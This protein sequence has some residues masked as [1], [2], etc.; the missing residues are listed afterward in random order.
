MA[1][2]SESVG[3]VDIIF[4]GGGTAACVAAGRLAKA[5]PDL[6]ILLVEGGRNN[7]NDPTVVN[8][9][10]YLSHLAP[11]STSALFYKAKS[12]EHLG[13]REAIVPMGG[14]LGGGSSINFMMYTRAQ[15]VD[16]DSW[17]TPGWA[18]KDM[19]PL[20][21]KL[22]T[23]HP[24]DAAID[25]SKHGHDGPIHI[26]DGGYR[27]KSEDQF[28]ETVT[29]MGHKEIVDLQDL[30]QCGG[31]SKWHRYI[32]PEGKR[33][34]S[35]HRYVHPLVEN[36]QQSNLYLLVESKVI[37][38]L[39]DESSPPRAIGIEYKPNPGAQP[40]ISLSKPVH[41]TVKANK[42]VVVTA[43]ALGTP[44]I[45]ERSG[46]GNPELLKKLDIPVVADVPG[47]G[48]NYQDH[49]LVLYPYKSNLAPDQTLDGILSGRKDFV[50]ALEEKDPI[51][52]WNGVDVCAKLRPSD[53]E[54]AKLGPEFQKDWDRDFAGIPSKPLMLCGVVSAFLAD[55]SLVEPGQYF[56]MGTYTAYP[57]SRGSIHITDKENVVDGYDFDA[58]FLSHPSDL[59]KQ[60]WAYKMSREISRRLPYYRGELELGHPKF[61]A[62]SKARLVD[63]PDPNTHADIE[64]SA[65]DDAAIVDWIRGNLNTTWHSLGT[66]AMR[67]R[68]KGGVVDADLN[69]YGTQ[70]LKVADLSMVPENVGANTNNTALV[71]GEKAAIII[72]NELGIKV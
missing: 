16:F 23:Y 19:L 62:G 36:G 68:A 9:A 46:V 69:V 24:K 22:E 26:S 3:D 58:G 71:V 59:K 48:E 39:F 43:G 45:L 44:Q 25:Q 67:A 33:Q 17:D 51:L 38:V 8:P 50:K 64:Y 53:A 55:P 2:Y 72:G 1:T 41:K 60:L 35:A 4:A 5:N 61:K 40:S 14:I 57:Y 15:G 30:E 18:A 52:G 29:K 63:G 56:T 7:F 34:D 27:A 65:E 42:L 6:K 37:R 31:F 49:H 20:C 54:I 12:S 66:C 70:G 10:V 28:M 13:G 47:V 32:S 11:D 21:N